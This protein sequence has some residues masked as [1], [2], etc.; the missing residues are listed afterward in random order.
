MVHPGML[1]G[2]TRTEARLQIHPTEVETDA[3][4]TV[5]GE[6]FFEKFKILLLKIL[7]TENIAQSRNVNCVDM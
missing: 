7:L 2:R 5:S 3:A 4:R 1:D 6:I